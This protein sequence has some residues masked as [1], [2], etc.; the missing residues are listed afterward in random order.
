MSEEETFSE[1]IEYVR[2][3]L[4][5]SKREVVKERLGSALLTVFHA[6]YSGNHQ[7]FAA[8]SLK[9]FRGRIAHADAIYSTIAEF[10]YPPKVSSLSRASFLESVFYCGYGNATALLELKPVLSDRIFMMECESAKDI[11][12]LKWITPNGAFDLHKMREPY[13]AFERLC[14]EAFCWPVQ[15]SFDYAISGLLASL[16]F[17]FSSVDGLAYSSSAT[18]MKGVNLALKASVADE[19]VVPR[20]FRAYRVCAHYGP[21]DFKIQCTNYALAPDQHGNIDWGEII[22]CPGHRV[23]LALFERGAAPSSCGD[24]TASEEGSNHSV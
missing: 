10:W 18:G 19:F 23:S 8:N 21:V 16:F 6:G 17:A 4:G 15:R 24:S 12:K 2:W 9:L 14:S 13:G 1:A 7:P 22:D 5:R 20:A 11:L 3:C